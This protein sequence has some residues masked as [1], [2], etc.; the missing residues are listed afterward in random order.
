MT[1]THLTAIQTMERLSVAWERGEYGNVRALLHPNGSWALVSTETRTFTDPDEFVEAVRRAHE[2]TG[3]NLFTVSHEQLADS[4]LLARADV[5][6]PAREGHG[7]DLARH[8][9]LVE[10]RDG[11]FYSSEHFPGEEEA[12]AALKGRGIA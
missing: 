9:F 6:A 8:F 10:V 12:R 2:E 4:V 3:Y 11:L 5:R 7:Y 1:P